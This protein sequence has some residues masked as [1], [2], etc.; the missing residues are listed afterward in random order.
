[1]LD[2]KE[3]E[4]ILTRFLSVLSVSVSFSLSLSAFHVPSFLQPTNNQNSIVA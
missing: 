4:K 3:K 1:M 2:T